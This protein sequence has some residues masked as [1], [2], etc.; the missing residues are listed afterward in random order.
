[1]SSLEATTR[2]GRADYELRKSSLNRKR[3]DR[4]QGVANLIGNIVVE[5]LYLQLGITLY[6]A[7]FWHKRVPT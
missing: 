1:M 5:L 4:F 3:L 7:G 6:D 2:A